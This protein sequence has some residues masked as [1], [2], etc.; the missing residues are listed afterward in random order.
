[1]SEECYDPKDNV[2]EDISNAQ[3]V[4]GTLK[5]IPPYLDANKTTLGA[6][7]GGAGGMSGWSQDPN[8]VASAIIALSGE[9]KGL[10]EGRVAVFG[11][12]IL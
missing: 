4:L 2:G 8:L 9:V 5:S 3:K 10:R 11:N 6:I 12:V 7:A 1:M